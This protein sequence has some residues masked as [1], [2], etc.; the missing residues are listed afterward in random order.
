MQTL[1][2]LYL[3]GGL[4]L[5][6]LSVPL[7]A[8]KIKPNPFYGFRV[9]QTLAQPELWYSINAFFAKRSF[10]VGVVQSLAAIAFYFIPNLS[11]DAYALACLGMFVIT[12]GIAMLQSV[13]YLKTIQ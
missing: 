13:R 8:G 1:L 2:Y 4:L 9:S 3:L 6:G 7:M 5:A 10:A 11:V 12:F